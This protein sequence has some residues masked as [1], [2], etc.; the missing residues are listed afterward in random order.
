MLPSEPGPSQQATAPATTR[1]VAEEM[2]RDM[3]EVCEHP[4][5]GGTGGAVAPY[6]VGDPAERAWS[7][8]IHWSAWEVADIIEQA[9]R[10]ADFEAASSLLGTGNGHP[11]RWTDSVA[12]GIVTILPAASA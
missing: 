11:V 4:H 7:V 10:A 2:G 12:G 5:A 9:Q 6:R 3:A 1:R 8:D